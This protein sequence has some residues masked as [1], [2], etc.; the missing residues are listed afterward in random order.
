MKQVIHW[1]ANEH[2]CLCRASTDNIDR[3][4]RASLIDCVSSIRIEMSEYERIRRQCLKRGE[5][6]EDPEFATTQTSVFY[7]QTPP[8]QFVWKRPKVSTHLS[9]HLEPCCISMY[10]HVFTRKTFTAQSKG[11]FWTA[12]QI[13]GLFTC[14]RSNCLPSG[15]FSA[16]RLYTRRAFVQWLCLCWPAL[17]PSFYVFMIVSLFVVK[18]RFFVCT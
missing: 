1:E 16:S 4:T 2:F 12:A 9:I 14:Q 11:K 18:K 10:I 3:G 8:Y 7:H 5:L 17:S 15:V 6:Y 13:W